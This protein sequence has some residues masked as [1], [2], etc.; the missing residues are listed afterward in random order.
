MRRLF[1]AMES[2][3]K[4]HTETVYTEVYRQCVARVYVIIEYMIQKRDS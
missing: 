3:A 2:V 1:L 4:D